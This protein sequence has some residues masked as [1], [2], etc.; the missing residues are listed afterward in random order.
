MQAAPDAPSACTLPSAALTQRLTWIRQVTRRSLL[1]HRLEGA[2]LWLR[3]RSDA[4]A[5]LEQIVA[6]ERECCSFLQF[7]LHE[8]PDGIE[9]TIRAPGG[10][11]KEAHWL[12]G[13]FLPQATPWRACGCAPGACG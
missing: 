7:E 11:G 6:G 3:Y 8:A 2:K 9:L 5:E 12:F 10:A 13:Q 4:R 1:S